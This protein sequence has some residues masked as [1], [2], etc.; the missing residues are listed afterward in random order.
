MRS[1]ISAESHAWDQCKGC[2]DGNLAPDAKEFK[3]KYRTVDELVKAAKKS[4]DPFMSGIKKN[5]NLLREA[6]KAL[7][8]K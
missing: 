8:L 5:E 2:H 7:G 1:Q 3:E 4:D 6:A